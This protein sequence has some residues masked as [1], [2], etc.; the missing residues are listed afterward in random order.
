M[1][2]VALL[3]TGPCSTVTRIF[4]PHIWLV[5]QDSLV[6]PFYVALHV[7]FVLAP[8]PKLVE[9]KLR[10]SRQ[11]GVTVWDH[12]IFLIFPLLMTP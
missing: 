8:K 1:F 2:Q 10:L 6:L 5:S 7:R 9:G 11:S 4:P 3:A 12:R